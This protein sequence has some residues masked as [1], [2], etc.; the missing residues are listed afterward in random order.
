MLYTWACLTKH[1]L[2]LFVADTEF[3][4]KTTYKASRL[5]KLVNIQ[6]SCPLVSIFPVV[7]IP[8]IKNLPDVTSKLHILL[9]YKK[10]FIQKFLVTISFSM[11]QFHGIS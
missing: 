7:Q 2:K 6:F 8:S 11:T 9:T 1:K 5:H 10:S 3:Q 4:I